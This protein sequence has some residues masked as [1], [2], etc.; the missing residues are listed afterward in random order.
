MKSIHNFPL[1]F[2]EN[3]IFFLKQL[4][5]QNCMRSVTTG[6]YFYSL[7]IIFSYWWRNT[8]VF[9]LWFWTLYFIITKVKRTTPVILLGESP[10]A[11]LEKDLSI[12]VSKS[13]KLFFSFQNCLKTKLHIFVYCRI[14][15]LSLMNPLILLTSFHQEKLLA[16]TRGHYVF[17]A[18]PFA[19]LPLERLRRHLLYVFLFLI[20]FLLLLWAL[21]GHNST[22]LVTF[23]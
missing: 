2:P 3:S 12:L 14:L 19:S 4:T 20:I 8:M 11:W 13:F 1:Y 22:Y 17:L 10:I 6:D 7:L 16:F 21:W 15:M 5:C 18:C 23:T 9:L